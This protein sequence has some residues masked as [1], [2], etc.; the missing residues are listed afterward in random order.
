MTLFCLVVYAA[1]LV[2][3]GPAVLTRLTHGGQA[4]RAGVVLWLTAI[5]SAVGT[6]M[7]ITAFV[8][9]DVITHW[10]Q[11]G[12]LAASCLKWLCELASGAAGLVPQFAVLAVVVVLLALAVGV[13]VRLARTIARLRGHAHEHGAAIRMVG[14]PLRGGDVYVVEAGERAAYCVSGRPSTIVVTS[15]AVAAL[16]ARELG[17]VIAHERA[18]L[19]GHH[20][21]IVT[22]LRGLAAVLPRVALFAWA[23]GEVARLLEM[24]ADDAAAHRFGERA[25][26][27][28]LMALVGAA[29]ASALGAADIAVLH[30]AGRL[31]D[32]ATRRARLSIRAVLT[33]ASAVIAVGP[34]G[35]LAV[36]LSGAWACIG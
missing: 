23:P 18:H 33:G 36:G 19:V 9:L 12:I 6:G 5:A 20:L 29:P 8:A 24:C 21:T 16:G 30:R 35:V 3:V 2:F 13:G 11:P 27:D 32:P 25:L 22:V 10:G 28:G 15:S 7:V 31:A 1:A 14:R 26:L 34:A 17:A 4:P